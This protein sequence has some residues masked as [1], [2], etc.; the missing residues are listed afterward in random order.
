MESQQLS[1]IANFIW[2]IAGNIPRGLYMRGKYRD[3]VL[4]MTVLLRLDVP[5]EPI[6]QAALA[7]KASLDQAQIVQAL[8][9]AARGAF[10]NPS[11]FTRVRAPASR[12]AD[13]VLFQG[14]RV[15]HADRQVP[16]PHQSEPQ[17]GPRRRRRGQA[18]HA[19]RT[20]AW[21]PC[22][23]NWCTASTTKGTK[24]RAS[25]GHRVTS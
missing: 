4:P 12:Q 3:V 2:G 6:K 15:G 8:R 19:S 1:C 17:F 5:Q 11:K 9:E 24:M 16:L 18:T 22:L 21:T 10:Y 7:M 20:T 25:T 14:R 23:R 13:L